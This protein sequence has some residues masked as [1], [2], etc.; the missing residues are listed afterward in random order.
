[1]RARLRRSI[2]H[3]PHQTAAF[4]MLAWVEA[5]A[6]NRDLRNINLVQSRFS[7]LSEKARTLVALAMVRVRLGQPADALKLLTSLPQL[8]PDLWTAQAAEVIAATI[9]DRPVQRL[10]DTRGGDVVHSELTPPMEKQRRLPTVAL[11][12]DL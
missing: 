11:P 6:E 1:M 2:E 10:A 9:E 12:D 8:E 7:S 4:E 3:E 5:F